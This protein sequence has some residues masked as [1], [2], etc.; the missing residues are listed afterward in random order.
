MRLGQ[1]PSTQLVSG[2]ERK[3][4]SL[5]V[6]RAWVLLRK[7][8]GTW[9]FTEALLSAIW[10]LSVSWCGYMQQDSSRCEP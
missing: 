2:P 8:Q 7:L 9:A 4:S 1:R 6:R 5:R 3:P 10:S